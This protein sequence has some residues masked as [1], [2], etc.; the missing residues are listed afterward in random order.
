MAFVAQEDLTWLGQLRHA[1]GNIVEKVRPGWSSAPAG[2]WRS[3]ELADAME[4]G[5][6]H[7]VTT[8]FTAAP[9]A[10]RASAHLL[11]ER[12]PDRSEYVLSTECGEPL[13]LARSKPGSPRVELYIP[14]G[15]DPPVAVG[16]AFTLTADDA[17][18]SAWTLASARCE[19]CEYLPPA[20]AQCHAG[21]CRCELA[22]IRHKR[23][24]IGKG[25]VMTMEVDLPALRQD[26]TPEVWCPRA[27]GD[28]SGL[29][30]ESRR[31]EWSKRIQSLTL[32]FYGRCNR[33]SPKNFQLQL[34]RPQQPRQKK[35]EAELLFGKID[36]DLFV[37][38]FK[39]PLGMAQAF[40]IAL[41]AKD[42]Q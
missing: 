32:D 19:C 30:L 31:P 6:A 16:P 10:E 23:E 36:D 18:K 40:A 41:T 25:T 27:G 1:A 5:V 28:R 17:G 8:S 21:A 33:A 24:D 3:F 13:L 39:H 11:V 29:Q 42:W 20:R 37:L 15:G 7:E 2:A 9:P 34:A 38:D 12:S 14:T 22:R 4:Q 35:Q 26:R